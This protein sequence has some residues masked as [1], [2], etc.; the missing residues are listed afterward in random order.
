MRKPVYLLGMHLEA[1]V[2]PVFRVE[3]V[4]PPLTFEMKGL[5]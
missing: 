3:S 2:G 4:R 1:I 5:F